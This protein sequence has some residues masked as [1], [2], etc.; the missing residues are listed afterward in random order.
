MAMRADAQARRLDTVLRATL[1]APGLGRFPFRNSHAAAQYSGALRFVR[2]EL[3][4][5]AFGINW[6][7]LPPGAEIAVREG[8]FL[9]FAPR[10]DTLP[11]GR[12]RM[13]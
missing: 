3:G 11:G 2:R 8:A 4:V 7:D 9:R 1:V 5:E 10:N 6:F 13:G 12:P